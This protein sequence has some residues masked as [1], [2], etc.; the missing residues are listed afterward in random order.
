MSQS[1]EFERLRIHNNT[2][3]TRL[4][5]FEWNKMSSATK[6]TS[7]ASQNVYL[8]CN[9]LKWTHRKLVPV[10]GRKVLFLQKK[11]SA[12]KIRLK[13]CSMCQ[14][15]C[16]TCWEYK[17]DWFC[18][19][20]FLRTP[21]ELGD[22]VSQRWQL[23]SKYWFFNESPL[24]LQHGFHPIW[25]NLPPLRHSISELRWS[26]QEWYG[27]KSINFVCTTRCEQRCSLRMD[28]WHRISRR[29]FFIVKKAN[30]R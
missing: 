10:F 26:W 12:N 14:P 1:I 11:D 2:S 30:P 27:S 23:V 29:V 13:T 21:S 7:D 22:R 9:T 6:Y 15:M 17:K 8:L 18:C 28:L 16:A 3:S 24:Y 19:A 20:P 25:D 5:V 4:W